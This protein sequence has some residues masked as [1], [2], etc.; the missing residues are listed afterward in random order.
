MLS[1]FVLVMGHAIHLG[2][3][4]GTMGVTRVAGIPMSSL[5]KAAARADASIKD[6]KPIEFG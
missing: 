5:I 4:A 2:H 6:I 3:P 1:S